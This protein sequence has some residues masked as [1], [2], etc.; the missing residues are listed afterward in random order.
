MG[1]AVALGD[2]VGEGQDIFV[3]AVVPF[4]RD[5]DADAV[6]NRRNGDRVGEQ[7][8]LGA[9][10]IADERADAAFIVKLMF[11]PLLVA[12]V[13]EYRFARPN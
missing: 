1:A 9:V 12:R 4:E 6:A 5:V 8:G 10:E 7:R 2:V 13:G 11:D 3:I